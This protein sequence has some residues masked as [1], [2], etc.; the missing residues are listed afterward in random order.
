MSRAGITSS[1]IE[2]ALTM[3]HGI[4]DRDSTLAIKYVN[5]DSFVNH[6]H[7]AYDGLQGIQGF[8][9]HLP[10]QSSA[11][12]VRAFQDGPYVFAHS[13]GDVFGR[14]IFFDIFRFEDGLI[15]EHWDN[16]SDQASPNVSGHTQIDGPLQATD[17]HETEK[18]KALLRDF[19]EKI[20]LEGKVGSMP[21]FFDGDKLIRHDSRGGDGLSELAALMHEQAHKGIVMQVSKIE[22]ILGEGNFVLVAASGSIAGEPVAYYDLFRVQDSKIAEH[23]NVIEEVPP[24]DQWKNKSGK[25]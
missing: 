12:V 22:M 3:F 8:I 21:Q 13:E 17:R 4:D 18:N 5:P 24:A 19:Y 20:F 10:P 11:K 14:K 9:N 16:I 1:N 15:V 25:F 23:W 7:R 6:N 2:K